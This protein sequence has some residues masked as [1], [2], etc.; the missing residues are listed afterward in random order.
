MRI[1]RTCLPRG[2]NSSVRYLLR[3]EWAPST[4]G[5][6][7]LFV[8][9]R[10]GEANASQDDAQTIASIETAKNLGYTGI[11][12]AFL[13]PYRATSFAQMDGLHND[14]IRSIRDLWIDQAANQCKDRYAVWG[15]YGAHCD[16][17][18]RVGGRL[19][20]MRCFALTREGNPKTLRDL[21]RSSLIT[22]NFYLDPRKRDLSSVIGT[23][24]ARL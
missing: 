19:R 13:F 3:R 5:N 6:L 7:A 18:V 22:K 4:R 20:P 15:D 23:A 24:E 12:L 2:K 11:I 10:P 1:D 17:D 21:D 9:L 14:K 16:E 8:H